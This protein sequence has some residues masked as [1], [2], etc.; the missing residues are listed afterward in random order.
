MATRFVLPF[1]QLF[2]EDRSFLTGGSLSFHGA[3]QTALKTVYADAGLTV[4]A[5]NPVVIDAAGRH[6]DIFLG[7]GDYRVV[8]KDAEGVQLWEADPV[9]GATPSPVAAAAGGTRRNLLLNG[10]FRVNQ[11]GLAG[12]AVADDGPALDGWYALTQAGTVT[13]SQLAD[14]EDGQVTA[15]RLVQPDGAAKRIGL[16][17]IVESGDCRHLRKAKMVLSGRVRLSTAAPLRYALLSWTGTADAVQSDVVADWTSSSYAAG[18]FFTGGLAV[19]KVGTITPAA[20]VWTDLDPLV[21]AAGPA[22][23]NL[24]VLVWT[25][26]TV[27]QNAQLDLGLMQ[28]EGGDAR[29]DFERVPFAATLARAQR[30]FCKSFPLAMAPAQN[31]GSAGAVVWPQVVGAAAA[32]RCGS[33]QFPARMRAAPAVT[34]YNPGA[35][36]AQVRNLD[37]PV[38]C[39]AA[40]VTASEHGFNLALT[41]GAG[42][43]AGQTLAVH[44]TADARL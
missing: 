36:N 13:V 33:I 43:A 41:T 17:Q 39:A 14:P 4:A 30:Y 25:E 42:S 12:T 32:Q 18:G 37:V 8:C 10:D 3:G 16:A 5:A 27:P 2:A 35:A 34:L 28:V 19:M 11:L 23:N 20:A 24:I 26:G 1:P 21:V 9:A 6:P 31:A 7:S 22:L 40:A 44:Y 15:I 38:D 29:T